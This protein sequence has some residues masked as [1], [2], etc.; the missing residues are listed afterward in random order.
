MH[1]SQSLSHTK[2]ECKYHIV[3]IPKYRKKALFAELRKYLGEM[4]RESWPGRKSA[5]CLKGISSHL[6]NSCLQA[7]QVF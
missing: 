4:L 5:R 2:L 3:W 7:A 1:D 6:N